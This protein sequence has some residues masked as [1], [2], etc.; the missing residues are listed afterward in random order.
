MRFTYIPSVPTKAAYE[1]KAFGDFWSIEAL[2]TEMARKEKLRKQFYTGY[3][4]FKLGFRCTFNDGTRGKPAARLW[5]QDPRNTCCS[6]GCCKRTESTP[7]PK[8]L[9]EIQAEDEAIKKAAEERE[10]WFVEKIN[11]YGDSIEF[12]HVADLKL[13]LADQKIENVAKISMPFEGFWTVTH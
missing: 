5:W 11:T 3:I 4:Y 8:T 9:E 6:K 10:A 13:K 12:R 7:P 2:L 1:N